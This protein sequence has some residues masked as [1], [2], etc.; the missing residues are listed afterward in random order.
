MVL[1]GKYKGGLWY[2]EVGLGEILPPPVSSDWAL[3]FTSPSTVK[4]E[5]SVTHVDP[6]FMDVPVSGVSCDDPPTQNTENETSK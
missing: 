3:V 1:R 6:G 4:D 2:H 5:G